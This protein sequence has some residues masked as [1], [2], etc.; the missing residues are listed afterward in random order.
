M[1]T[2]AVDTTAEFGSIALADASGVREEVLLYE[3]KGFSGVLFQAIEALLA[4]NRVGLRDIELFAGA[5]GPGSFTGVRIGLAAIK[6]L[7]EVMSRPA[8]GISNLRALAEFGSAEARAVLIDARRGEVYAALYDP[9][10]R[11]VLPEMVAPFPAFLNALVGKRFEWIS[12]DF[13]P[14]R[15]AVESGEFRDYPV[16]NAPRA[17]AATIARLAI[18]RASATPLPDA[19]AVD[20][21]YVR[22]SDA[23]L[24]WRDS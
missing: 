5:S 19:A 11:P 20:A 4:R 24:L 12:T 9:D 7:A 8:I 15:M 3:P 23:E 6:G 17:L 13:A 16:V 1:L 21:N 14:F 22:R 2:L 18:R 10:G